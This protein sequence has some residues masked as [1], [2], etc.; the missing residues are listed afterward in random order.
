MLSGPLVDIQAELLEAYL[1]ARP[2]VCS[3]P[4]AV[5]TQHAGWHRLC[6]A[7][8]KGIMTKEVELA[9]SLHSCWDASQCKMLKGTCGFERDHGQDSL[10]EILD[11]LFMVH[12]VCCQDKVIWWGSSCELLWSRPV[13]LLHRNFAKL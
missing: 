9:D 7:E 12:A 13:Q 10:E 1:R 6:P 11:Q 8:S 5:Q 2:Y 3:M 4:I